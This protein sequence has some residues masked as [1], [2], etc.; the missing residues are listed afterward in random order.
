MVIL[1]T[2]SV[3]F[4][5]IAWVFN[6][7]LYPW[8]SVPLFFLYS[9]CLISTFYLEGGQ[10]ARFMAKGMPP[11]WFSFPTRAIVYGD[12]RD[13]HFL[14]RYVGVRQFLT[15][16][17]TTLAGGWA[18][19]Y[20]Q[21]PLGYLLGIEDETF[22]VLLTL[23]HLFAASILFQ[24]LP[25][26]HANGSPRFLQNVFVLLS[27]Y[28]A[29][30]LGRVVSPALP[31]E[32]LHKAYML[33]SK[34]IIHSWNKSTMG[35]KKQINQCSGRDAPVGS[36][37]KMPNPA[38][39]AEGGSQ[40][41]TPF[42]SLSQSALII[43]HPSVSSNPASIAE[44]DEGL[45]Q[46]E[47]GGGKD[48][49]EDNDNAVRGEARDRNDED[50]EEDEKKSLEGSVEDE[51]DSSSSSVLSQLEQM[52]REDWRFAPLEADSCPR[53]LVLPS[54]ERHIPPHILLLLLHL[55]HRKRSWPWQVREAVNTS[56]LTHLRVGSTQR[57]RR[58]QD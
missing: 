53:W 34:L 35:V 42:L 28:V 45:D 6:M 25:Q 9:F 43:Q 19:R 47:G 16:A 46:E 18:I 14:E 40:S 54:H 49:Y 3:A 17:F 39:F 5:A 15:L 13:P 56:I 4:L 33:L 23:S 12:S 32:Y 24:I 27:F 55:V 29:D 48:D 51:D 37:S 52:E 58:R 20:L 7:L 10:A 50:D 57:N 38:S 1:L 36:A 44:E 2:C 30:A 22:P 11:S 26:V 21:S 31:A 8:E 41:R